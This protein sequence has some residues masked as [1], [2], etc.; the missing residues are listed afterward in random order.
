MITIVL[1][2]RNRDLKIVQNCLDSLKDQSNLSFK[3]ILIDYG[4]EDSNALALSKFVGDYSFVQL[5]SCPVKKQLWNKARA[6]N[7]AL[8]QCTTTCFFVGDIDMIF[9]EDF[10]EKLNELKSEDEITYFQVGFLDQE[11][12]KKSKSFKTYKVNHLSGK[13]ATGMT[14]YSTAMLKSINGYD[15]FYHGWGAEDT[16]VHIRLQ[17]KKV[18]VNFYNDDLYILHQWHPKTYRNKS[19]L[20]PFHSRLEKINHQ[21]IQQIQKM[22][23][24]QANRNSS[25]G[26]LPVNQDYLSLNQPDYSLKITNEKNDIEAFL[27]GTLVNLKDV[28]I[29]VDIEKHALCNS[30]KNECKRIIGKKHF[31][32]L[33][34]DTINDAILLTI[35]SS[36]RNQPYQY[37]YSKL[38]QTINLKIK[39]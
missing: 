28:V 18:K 34:F 16:D 25:W 20:E 11:E 6:I 12:S 14:L 4:S 1:T 15:E 33:S 21:Y 38:E 35:V 32:F 13:E 36:L 3:V 39:L 23:V 17:N 22:K 29:N 30:F 7:I 31:Q 27:S 19:S 37:E 5:I 26:I 10:I 24:I 9:R 2:Y 8:L